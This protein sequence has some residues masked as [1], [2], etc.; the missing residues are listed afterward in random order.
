K[1]RLSFI[2]NNRRVLG[3]LEPLLRLIKRNPG[4]FKRL[5]IGIETA[6]IVV[7]NNSVRLGGSNI[8]FLDSVKGLAVALKASTKD[9]HKSPLNRTKLGYRT[10]GL[11]HA[12]NNSAGYYGSQ[13]D[14]DCYIDF[15][16][17]Q[18]GDNVRRQA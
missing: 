9:K 8:N 6:N 10:A 16:E 1:E 5:V 18:D 17:A 2:N 15:R 11:I 12:S 13:H 4:G 3:E 14:I 7:V